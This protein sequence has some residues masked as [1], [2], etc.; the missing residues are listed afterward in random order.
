MRLLVISILILQSAVFAQSRDEAELEKLK[1]A[2]A[3]LEK[4]LAEQT[5]R[6]KKTSST[7]DNLDKKI[8]L[9]KNLVGK[10]SNDISKQK[11]RRAS[12]EKEKDTLTQRLEKVQE[13]FAQRMIS[14]YKNGHIGT[15]ELLVNAKNVNQVLL[16]AEYQRRLAQ[17]DAKLISSIRSRKAKL[18]SSDKHVAL[19]IQKQNRSLAERKLSQKKLE[20]S[21]QS[22]Q[23]LLKQ[24]RKN[25]EVYRQQVADYMAAIERIQKIISESEAQ[26]LQ[27]EREQLQR[28]PG[29]AEIPADFQEIDFASLKGSLPWPVSGEIIREY[30]SYKHPVLKTV[31]ANLG[32]DI[33][34]QLGSSVR[35]VAGGK[36]TAITWQRGRGNLIIVNHTDGFYTVYTHID[37]IA[38][39]LRETIVAGT[40][41]GVVGEAGIDSDPL[42]HFQVWQKFDHLDPKLWLKR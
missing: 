8:S 24:I 32:I 30:G 28:L 20:N 4:S 12:L 35:S 38:V 42:I 6:E 5:T 16:W 10:L 14:L 34:A 31:T 2:I 17:M 33:K 9:S 27:E 15:L 21:R 13:I 37:E 19:T 29:L 22:K 36:V 7:V 3:R 40:V 1:D 23:K 26:R 41:L 18:D 11:E 25:K 39:D